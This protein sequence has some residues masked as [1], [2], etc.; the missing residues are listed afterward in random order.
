M[1]QMGFAL[2]E[3]GVAEERSSCVTGT[4]FAAGCQVSKLLNLWQSI[5]LSIFVASIPECAPL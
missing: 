1:S 2:E 4:L 5:E 3:K